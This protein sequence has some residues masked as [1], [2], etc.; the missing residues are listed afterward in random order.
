M[1][2]KHHILLTESLR[3]KVEERV[4]EVLELAKKKYNTDFNF[5]TI[6]YD[7]KSWTGGLA[8]ANRNLI[9]L[10]LILLVENEEHY[11]KNTVAHEVAH[12]VARKV[13]KKRLD[14]KNKRIMPHGPEWKD[15]MATFNIEPAVKHSYNCASIER[16]RYN[17][18]NTK[19]DPINRI[20]KHI[21]K[22][23]LDQRNTLYDMIQHDQI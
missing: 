1:T 11:I 4:I 7:I 10:N 5:P 12:L 15:V 9:R 16:I 3:K 8:Y 6:R 2:T 13:F 14:G 17:V 21:S 20:I 23:T 19:L 18:I 22:L